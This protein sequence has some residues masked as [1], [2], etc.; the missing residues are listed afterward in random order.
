MYD[1]ESSRHDERLVSSAGEVVMAGQSVIKLPRRVNR[2]DADQ[3]KSFN[4]T[5]ELIKSKINNYK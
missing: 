2:R 5:S 1:A 4:A 3:A